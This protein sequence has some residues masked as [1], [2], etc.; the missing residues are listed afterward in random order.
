M[1]WVYHTGDQKQHVAGRSSVTFSCLVI[2]N[3]LV[4]YCLTPPDQLLQP[5]V[6]R[7]PSLHFYWH[8]W[9]VLVFLPNLPHLSTIPDPKQAA[10]HS[11]GPTR[12][13]PDCKHTQSHGSGWGGGSVSGPLQH[14]G[15]VHFTKCTMSSDRFPSLSNN[16]VNSRLS[17]LGPASF[18]T[19]QSLSAVDYLDLLV[20]QHRQN[21]WC[22]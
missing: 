17:R 11:R 14:T 10:E 16:H 21:S 6:S 15:V 4:I 2:I 13:N 8:C 5:G 12:P 19:I 7:G 1:C 22:R 18:P 20:P 9:S 3:I